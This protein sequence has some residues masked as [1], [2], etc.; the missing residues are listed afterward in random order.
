M[1]YSLNHIILMYWITRRRASDTIREIIMKERFKLQE[2]PSKVR[3]LFP[4]GN[5][6][7]LDHRQLLKG[8]YQQV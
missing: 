7:C 5:G 4:I 8:S 3:G 6:S 2:E 1:N